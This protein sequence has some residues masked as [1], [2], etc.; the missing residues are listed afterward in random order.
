MAAN[1]QLSRSD[2]KQDSRKQES[3]QVSMFLLGK[4]NMIDEKDEI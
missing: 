4:E 2:D 3:D 1:D